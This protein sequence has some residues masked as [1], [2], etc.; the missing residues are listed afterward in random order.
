VAIASQPRARA[1]SAEDVD[2]LE[3][4]R[5]VGEVDRHAAGPAAFTRAAGQR[6]AYILL[7]RAQQ[8]AF[9]D[10]RDPDCEACRDEVHAR[11]KAAVVR[12]AADLDG[13][14]A[15]AHQRRHIGGELGV[16]AGR[17]VYHDVRL[18]ADGCSV[19]ARDRRGM[20]G[21]ASGELGTLCVLT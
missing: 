7:D 3:H 11:V 15:G 5:C 19:V 20:S 16:T 4:A 10:A 21:L 12:R 9:R 2:P 17:V 1:S 14:P 6:S 18:I 13:E 8:G